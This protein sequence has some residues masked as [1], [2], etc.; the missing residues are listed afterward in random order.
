MDWTNR[1]YFLVRYSRPIAPEWMKLPGVKCYPPYNHFKQD[2]WDECVQ[3]DGG[4]VMQLPSLMVSCD[5]NKM[6][7]LIGGFMKAG[8]TDHWMQWVELSKEMCGQ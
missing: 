3:Y 6:E 8:R 2:N 7:T 4:K 5:T 1:S